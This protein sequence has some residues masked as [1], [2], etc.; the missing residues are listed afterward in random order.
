MKQAARHS[1]K[2]LDKE[3]Y[4]VE[5]CV[6]NNITIISKYS[7]AKKQKQQFLEGHPVA[8]SRTARAMAMANMNYCSWAEEER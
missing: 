7:I 4:N 8:V 5:Q 3:S 6:E 1:I 2:L